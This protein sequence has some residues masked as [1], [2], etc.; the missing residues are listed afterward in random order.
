[1]ATYQDGNV[2]RATDNSRKAA[3]ASAS[4]RQC[5]QCKRKSALVRFSDPSVGHGSEC[6]WCGWSNF[7][8]AVWDDDPQSTEQESG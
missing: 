1:M 4:A 3:S 5:P 2:R 6:R 8:P 7:T